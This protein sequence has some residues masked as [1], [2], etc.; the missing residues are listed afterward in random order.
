MRVITITEAEC[1]RWSGGWVR[2]CLRTQAQ[3]AGRRTAPLALTHRSVACRSLGLRGLGL[4]DGV[5][6]GAA[7]PRLDDVAS[8]V[9]QDEVGAGTGA[10]RA[11]V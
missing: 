5:D 3:I 6:A 9:E 2:G 1:G 11:A 4:G 8:G 10:E 7:D